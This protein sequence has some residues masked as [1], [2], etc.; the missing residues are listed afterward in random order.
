[1]KKRTYIIVVTNLVIV[2]WIYLWIFK[3]FKWWPNAYI[4]SFWFAIF[5]LF[6]LYCF[7][8]MLKLIYQ[9]MLINLN[10]LFGKNSDVR[11][12]LKIDKDWNLSKPKTLTKGNH[13]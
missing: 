3:E 11:Y 9:W 13:N 1:M 4:I 8:F 10:K 2:L 7:W 5:L 12:W 6:V